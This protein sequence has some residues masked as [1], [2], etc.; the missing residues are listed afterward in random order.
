MNLE[1]LKTQFG[2]REPDRGLDKE[3]PDVIWRH[4]AIPNYTLAN[5]S[6]LLGKTQN[7][8]AGKL[9]F[10]YVF[11]TPPALPGVPLVQFHVCPLKP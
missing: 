9:C 1:D 3:N 2:F 10:L 11:L 5:T 7:H 6:F 4:G 8:K